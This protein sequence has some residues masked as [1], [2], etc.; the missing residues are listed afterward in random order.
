MDKYTENLQ[1]LA[2][3]AF[4]PKPGQC[5]QIS[6]DPEKGIVFAATTWP[7]SRRRVQSFQS[8]FHLEA[9]WKPV[10]IV[11]RN[12][13]SLPAAMITLAKKL[14]ARCGTS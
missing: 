12:E 5:V 1:R 7:V 14:A 3:E 9:G 11:Y 6:M 2:L 13:Q 8:K 4:Q 10:V